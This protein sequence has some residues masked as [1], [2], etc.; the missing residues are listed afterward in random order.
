MSQLDTQH[1]LLIGIETGDQESWRPLLTRWQTQ[2]PGAR[3]ETV[4]Q[5]RPAQV[6]NLKI[7]WQMRLAPLATGKLW[8]WSDADIIAPDGFLSSICAEFEAGGEKALTNPYVIRNL[9]RVQGIPDALFINVEF[10]P[11]VLL[12][13]KRGNVSFAFGAGTLFDAGEFRRKVDW[14]KLGAALADDFELGK[15]ME[16]VAI[17]R[18][19][20][21]TLPEQESWPRSLRHYFRWSKTIRWCQPWGYAAQIAIV[22]LLGWLLFALT[23]PQNPVAWCGLL[24]ISQIETAA[25]VLICRRIGC[26]ISPR[27]LWAVEA[28]TVLRPLVWLA[29]WLPLPVQWGD[30]PAK[31]WKPTQHQ[32]PGHSSP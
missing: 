22:P 10:F 31:W 21:E 16:P 3:F 15:L 1:E 28:W 2:Y 26:R 9:E 5:R 19:T 20:V 25:A 6:A 8:L 13:R 23:H 18:T 17:S 4:V 24:A 11:G 32:K 30:S 12:L 29:S 27:W 14:L 7:A